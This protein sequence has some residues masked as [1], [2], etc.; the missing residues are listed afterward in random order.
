M[1]DSM[2]INLGY[3][4]LFAISEAYFCI[5]CILVLHSEAPFSLQGERQIGAQ[6]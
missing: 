5:N 4:N 3:Y 6:G 2:F 1:L